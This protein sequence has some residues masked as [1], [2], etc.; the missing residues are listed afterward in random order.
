MA[1][2]AARAASQTAPTSRSSTPASMPVGRAVSGK[3]RH[4]NFTV[5]SLLLPPAQR[6]GLLGI[7]R[8]ARL[9]DDA[10]DEAPGDRRLLL[11]WLEADVERMFSGRPIHPELRR[12][13]PSTR[14]F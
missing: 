2:T 11:D 13:A 4:E 5:A 8:F 1:A 3:A 10:G 12:L 14:R 6:R 7:Y 9:V